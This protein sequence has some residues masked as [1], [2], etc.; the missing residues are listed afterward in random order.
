RKGHAGER[1]LALL[2]HDV[3][4]PGLQ[5]RI[6]IVA[7]QLAIVAHPGIAP[8]RL[9][10]DRTGTRRWWYEPGKRAMAPDAREIRNGCACW[11]SSWPGGLGW[12]DRWWRR[13]SEGGGRNR[14][15]QSC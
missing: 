8:A 5:D 4:C 11:S 13:L 12:R 10:G 7:D 3:C 15:H 2:F 9:V 14:H 1:Q 6:C